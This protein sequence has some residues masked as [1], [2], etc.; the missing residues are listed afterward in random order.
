MPLRIGVALVNVRIAAS[1]H[2]MS[3]TIRPAKTCHEDFRDGYPELV[4]VC[5]A[6]GVDLDDAAGPT[7][8]ANYLEVAHHANLWGELPRLSALAEQVDKVDGAGRPEMR[9]I[10]R[11]FEALRSDLES[12]LMCEEQIVFP[13]IREIIAASRTVERPNGTMRNPIDVLD[14]DHERVADG[15]D[16]LASLT[17]DFT[18]PDGASPEIRNLYGGL[19]ALVTDTR[20]HIRLEHHL[21]FPAVVAVERDLLAVLDHCA[22]Q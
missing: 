19:A 2:D 12:H 18:A 16:E 11:S 5:R 17:D 14:D 1:G 15:L 21:L 20:L 8:L 7:A 13:L 6:A 4:A 3:R 22:P 9:V 10:R